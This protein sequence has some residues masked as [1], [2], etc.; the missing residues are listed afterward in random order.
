[1]LRQLA[2]GAQA[3]FGGGIGP[4]ISTGAPDYSGVDADPTMPGNQLPT[5]AARQDFV[6]G[7][8]AGAR[9]DT[10]VNTAF[11]SLEGNLS[12][13]L[14]PIAA[15]T[16]WLG[17]DIHSD[18]YAAHARQSG[19]FADYE[20]SHGMTPLCMGGADRRLTC[21]SQRQDQ[22][23][24]RLG[25]AVEFAIDRHWNFWFIFEGILAQPS[26]HRRMLSGFLFDAA[27]IRIYPRLGFTYKF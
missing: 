12:L 13:L 9:F 21:A 7:V 11:F 1:M 26:D 22:A 6:P 2:V 3:R 10:P 16:L 24:M 8:V 14:D 25:G 19:A 5:F 15:V 20:P 17:L 23:R 27:D 18:E 4:S